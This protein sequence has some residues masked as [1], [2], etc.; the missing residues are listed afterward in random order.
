M[1]RVKAILLKLRCPACRL[2]TW[3]AWT[4][5]RKPQCLPCR[6]K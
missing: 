1:K 3:H 6:E 4:P 5:G 2:D